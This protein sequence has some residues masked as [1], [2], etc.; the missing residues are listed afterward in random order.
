[1]DNMQMPHD[2]ADQDKAQTI[3]LIKQTLMKVIQDMTA[4]ESDRMLPDGHPMKIKAK[5]VAAPTDG[6][7]DSPDAD[8][9]GTSDDAGSDD[10]KMLES[11]MGEADKSDDQ[12]MLPEDHENDL[13]PEI[14]DAVRKKK[15]ASTPQ[16]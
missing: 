2:D 15:A 9:S 4:M 12:G 7:T 6:S 3:D 5:V 1:M 10:P 13:P 14:L 16:A 8:M 11:L